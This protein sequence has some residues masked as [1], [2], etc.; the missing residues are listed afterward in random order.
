MDAFSILSTARDEQED[1]FKILKLRTLLLLAQIQL[2]LPNVASDYERF[3][4]YVILETYPKNLFLRLNLNQQL[5]SDL[6]I[7]DSITLSLV[8]ISEV[9]VEG[10]STGNYNMYSFVISDM[11]DF[12]DRLFNFQD[13]VIPSLI[14]Y[15][16][17]V[18]MSYGSEEYN[19]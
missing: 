3:Y 11:N 17:T 19:P 4:A 9:V 7:I 10:Y 5:A 8:R 2:Y 16:S 12:L 15:N 1:S 14:Y 18:N 6:E 13:F